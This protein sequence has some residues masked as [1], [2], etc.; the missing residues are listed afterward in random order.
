M[1]QQRK[2]SVLDQLDEVPHGVGTAPTHLRH[3]PSLVAMTRALAVPS[4]L[5][6]KVMGGPLVAVHSSLLA[7]HVIAH[8]LID[9][10]GRQAS[11]TVLVVVRV[12][13][14]QSSAHHC[15]SRAGDSQSVEEAASQAEEAS[16]RSQ[17]AAVVRL[18]VPL[19]EVAETATHSRAVPPPWPVMTALEAV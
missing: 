8:T 17:A 7:A 14:V 16:R 3:I 4:V 10:A 5:L 18:N 2:S 15:A 1:Q 19:H 12:A 9:A 13:A 6:A 11:C